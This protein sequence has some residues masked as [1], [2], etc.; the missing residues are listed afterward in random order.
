MFLLVASFIIVLL[1]LV[2]QFLP[3]D[4]A[5]GQTPPLEKDAGEKG[6]NFFVFF[7]I[8]R[9]RERDSGESAE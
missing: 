5:F 4:T 7:Y 9:E 6:A 8:K 2:A 3:S 1:V